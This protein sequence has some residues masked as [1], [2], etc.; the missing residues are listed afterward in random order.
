MFSPNTAK[1]GPEITPFWTFFKQWGPLY[2]LYALLK[3]I[4]KFTWKQQCQNSIL[5]K[6][7]TPLLRTIC[8]NIGYTDPN[9]KTCILPYFSQ[10]VLPKFLKLVRF[11][12]NCW[13]ISCRKFAD[14]F[15]VPEVFHFFSCIWLLC[16]KSLRKESY[17]LVIYFI[18]SVF[19]HFPFSKLIID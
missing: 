4:T 9:V 7:Q 17:N 3:S 15:C 12:K 16:S 6:L 13:P 8:E 18:C 5:V 11:R 14:F 19:I 2:A 10:W 1:Y